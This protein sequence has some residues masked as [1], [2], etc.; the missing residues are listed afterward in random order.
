MKNHTE[1]ENTENI[2]NKM[3]DFIAKYLVRFFANE[4]ED[5]NMPEIQYFVKEALKEG[6]LSNYED[7]II[8][9]INTGNNSAEIF[10]NIVDENEIRKIFKELVIEKIDTINNMICNITNNNRNIAEG[11]VEGTKSY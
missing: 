11:I 7:E 4:I 10:G 1:L 5:K 8:A 3:T 2:R 6:K 9:E